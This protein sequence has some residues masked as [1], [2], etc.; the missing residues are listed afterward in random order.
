MIH[1]NYNNNK[2]LEF[3]LLRLIYFCQCINSKDWNI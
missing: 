1:N 2:Q 3:E